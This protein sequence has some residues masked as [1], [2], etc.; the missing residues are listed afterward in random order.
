MNIY[1]NKFSIHSHYRPDWIFIIPQIS[2]NIHNNDCIYFS[3]KF[4]KFDFTFNFY[5]KDR[6][7]LS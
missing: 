2:L 3:I 7:F 5:L 6:M 1:G 4:I